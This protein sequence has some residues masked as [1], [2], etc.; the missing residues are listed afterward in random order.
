MRQAEGSALAP[1]AGDFALQRFVHAL[2][3]ERAGQGVVPHQ[4]AGVCQFVLQA[5]DFALGLI[6]PCAHQRHFVAGTRG[7][8]LDFTGFAHHFVQ[9]VGEVGDVVGLADALAHF[10]ILSW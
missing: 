8:E 3:V 6:D 5:A 1:Q 9:H 2:A 10:S 4:F 7:I